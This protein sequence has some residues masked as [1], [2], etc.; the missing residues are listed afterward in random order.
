MAASSDSKKTKKSGSGCLGK[1]SLFIVLFVGF[2][3]GAA[4]FFIAQPQD[5]SDI[6]GFNPTVKNVPVRDLKDVLQNSLDRGYKVTLTET[7]INQWIGR[8]L[9]CKQGGLLGGMVSL[10]Q[11]WIRLDEGVAEVILE[12]TIMGKPFTTS[13]FL[14][15]EQFQG[16]H[17]VQTAAHFNGGPYHSLL[18]RPN[19]GGRFGKLVVPE[20]FLILVRPAFKKLV[21]VFDNEIELGIRRMARVR[22]EKNRL[23]LDPNEPGGDASELP[24]TF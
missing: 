9:K 15:L 22:I 19:R 5:L 6:G 10:D 23:V 21:P 12:R 18:P 16:E 8:N 20:G 11:M 3:I 24:L 14:K 1:L 7:E 4:A 2:G 13:M 17:G